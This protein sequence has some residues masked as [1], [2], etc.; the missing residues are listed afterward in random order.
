MGFGTV[1]MLRKRAVQVTI[2]LLVRNQRDL[3]M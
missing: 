2:V 1:S 3:M